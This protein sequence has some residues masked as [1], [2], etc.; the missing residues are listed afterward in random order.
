MRRAEIGP[1]ACVILAVLGCS[2]EGFPESQQPAI[3][4]RGDTVVLLSGAPA[5]P[6]GGVLRADLTIGLLEGPE[7][8]LFGRVGDAAVGRDWSIYV[9]DSQAQIVRQYTSDGVFMRNLGG[10]GDGPGEFRSARMVETDTEGR[11]LIGEVRSGDVHVY[12]F[13]GDLVETWSLSHAIE[14]PI[15]VDTAGLAYVRLQ[16]MRRE[17]YRLSDDPGRISVD[18]PNFVD[19]VP[20]RSLGSE[21]PGTVRLARD[22]TVVDTVPSP[23]TD[24][25]ENYLI[26]P[27]GRIYVGLD[28]TPRSWWTWSPQGYLMTGRTDRYAI[29]L[30]LVAASGVD[31]LVSLRRQRDRISIRPE[32]QEVIATQVAALLGDNDVRWRDANPVP[33]LKPAY[34]RV[35]GARDGRIWIRLHVPSIRDPD[36]NVHDGSEWFEPE[37]AFDVFEPSGHYLGEV[38]G[39]AGIRATW[40]R[41]DTLLVISTDELGVDTVTRLIVVWD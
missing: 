26:A 29:D 33:Q 15:T 2:S 40:A 13:D 12:S 6:Q 19:V 37:S 20:D 31:S 9:L 35:L 1:L 11:V 10:P 4:V 30:H 27:S 34:H 24:D 38:R 21:H 36:S 18:G 25:I 17:S 28:Y 23:A 8:Y 39:P 5:H 32:V 41:G 3:S 14:P 22:G 7:E 16:G